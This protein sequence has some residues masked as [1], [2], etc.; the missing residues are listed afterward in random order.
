MWQ[1][2]RRWIGLRDIKG[3]SLAILGKQLWRMDV[4]S[5]SLLAR[6]YK[7]RYFP[8]KSPV[9]APFGTRLSFAWRSIHWAQM[10]MK[11][12][13]RKE[14]GNGLNVNLVMDPWLP[15]L[16]PRVENGIQPKSISLAALKNKDSNEWNMIRVREIFVEDV[17]LIGQIRTG[18]VMTDGTFS[19]M[20][21][22][23]VI[24]Q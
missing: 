8:T 1:K 13:I 5:T 4:E 10:L 3:F 17:R 12:G 11:E 20:L 14:F 2:K 23:M 6:V 15:V 22:R 21:I 18:G 24:T 19:W 7:G 16:P 9:D